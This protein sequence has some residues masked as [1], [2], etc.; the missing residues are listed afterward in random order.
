MLK[1]TLRTVTNYNC[2]HIHY[3]HCYIHSEDD[4]RVISLDLP[5]TPSAEKLEMAVP[6]VHCSPI[7]YIPSCTGH[8]VFSTWIRV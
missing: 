6:S 8:K 4:C 1:L 5:R 3:Y 7:W 2:N